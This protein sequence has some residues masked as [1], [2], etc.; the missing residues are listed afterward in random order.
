[1]VRNRFLEAGAAKF[2]FCDSTANVSFEKLGTRN[3][4]LVKVLCHKLEGPG[5]ET[6]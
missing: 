1:M 3:S 5:F 4:V 2:V 6:R